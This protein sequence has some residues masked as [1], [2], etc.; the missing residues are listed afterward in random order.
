MSVR[1]RVVFASGVAGAVGAVLLLS[2]RFDASAVLALLLV[3]A[4][5]TAALG[6]LVAGGPILAAGALHGLR[7]R[8]WVAPAWALAVAAAVVRAG[9]TSLPDVRGANAVVGPAL[10]YGPAATVAGCW[11]A[12]AAAAL[13]I[14]E[15]RPLGVDTAG[16]PTTIGRVAV[17]ATVTR[18]DGVGVLAEAALVVSLFVGP[19][20]VAGPDAAWYA[21]GIAV[22]VAGVWLARR[23]RLVAPISLAAVSAALGTLGLGLVLIGGAP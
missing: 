23:R 19:Q 15:W 1:S 21:A 14:L 3:F 10:A 4:I 11:L 9:S 22:I 18:L 20:V 12:F 2:G 13:A 17:P 16:A 8:V 5:R 7:N 6:T